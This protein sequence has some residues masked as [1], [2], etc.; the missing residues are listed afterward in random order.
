MRLNGQSYPVLGG[1]SGEGGLLPRE[2]EHLVGNVNSYHGRESYAWGTPHDAGRLHSCLTRKVRAVMARK[3]R[4]WIAR[5]MPPWW[6]VACAVTAVCITT[7]LSAR[8]WQVGVIS[9]A[10]LAVVARPPFR[11]SWV[12]RRFWRWGTV[13]CIRRRPG[14]R[15]GTGWPRRGYVGKTR[16]LDY[17]TRVEQH[18]YGYWRGGHWKPPQWW[19]AD[20]YDYFPVW[21]GRWTTL[22][23]WWREI[24]CIVFLFPVHNDRWNK[25]NPRRVISP[26]VAQRVY[27]APDQI[28][29]RE[30][31]T[32]SRPR[33]DRWGRRVPERRVLRRRDGSVQ[34]SGRRQ[35]TRIHK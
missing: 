28:T 35:R 9:L 27:P 19:A 17:R 4:S 29:A 15:P 30:R 24:V 1:D 31:W 14:G 18:L 23:L 8:Q 34:V 5:T 13:Y 16:Q 6:P 21:S 26:P 7:Y 3:R 25:G 32:V 12:Y 10:G 22:G 20:A 33:H 2:L 11:R